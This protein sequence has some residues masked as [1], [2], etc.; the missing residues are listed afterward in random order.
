M[1]VLRAKMTCKQIKI[2]SIVLSS[3]MTPTSQCSETILTSFTSCYKG[4]EEV[5]GIP[6]HSVLP[7]NLRT[8][9]GGDGH[10]SCHL[11]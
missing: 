6:L 3:Y 4:A 10:L 9:S 2:L 11:V 7:C 8:T 1:F 5:V